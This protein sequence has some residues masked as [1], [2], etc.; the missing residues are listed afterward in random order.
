[1]MIRQI[2]INNF[3]VMVEDIDIVENIFG[4]NVSTL[5]V[6]ITIK[7][8]NVFM[9]DFIEIPRELIGYNQELILCVYIMFINQQ[10]LL[11]TIDKDILF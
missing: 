1:M 11:P 10:A 8:P 9:D 7:R 6:R 4:P 5:K 3:P 2:F